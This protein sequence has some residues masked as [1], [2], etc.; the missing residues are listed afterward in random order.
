MRLAG[1]VSSEQKGNGRKGVECDR[2]KMK[3]NERKIEGIY[4]NIV[5]MKG[6]TCENVRR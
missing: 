1:N 6:R 2:Q 3:E 5:G 4:G